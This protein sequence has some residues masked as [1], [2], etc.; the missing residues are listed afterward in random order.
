MATHRIYYDD[1]FARDFDA[2]VLA[3]EPAVHG[4]TPAWE[5]VLDETALYPMSGGQ[6]CDHGKLG[7]AN[8]LDVRDDGDE[9]VHFADRELQAGP[10][11]GGVGWRGRLDPPQQHT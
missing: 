10:L 1:S 3:C 9:V 2:Q 8:V 6:P 4:T 7:D 11:D 5:V